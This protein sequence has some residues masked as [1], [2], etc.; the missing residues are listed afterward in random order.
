MTGVEGYV[1]SAASGLLS[2]M[3][4]AGDLLG[5]GTVE[6]PGI[7]A[8]GAMGRYVATPN[9]NFQP[10]NCSFGLI[11]S[12]PVDKEHKKIRNKAMR[13]EAISARSLAYLMDWISKTGISD[14]C[15]C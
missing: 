1:E 5:L 13:Y 10:M 2:G 8:M 6:L 15:S 11:D 14:A 12:L 7:T 3:S 4:L 9:R